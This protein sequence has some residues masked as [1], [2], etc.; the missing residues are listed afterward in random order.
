MPEKKVI[1]QARRDEGT[2][3][4]PRH[5]DGLEPLGTKQQC[6]QCGRRAA[7]DYVERRGRQ[8]AAARGIAGCPDGL[9]TKL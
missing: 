3:P 8:P 1:E 7:R 5:A 9:S 6:V 2:M 4:R